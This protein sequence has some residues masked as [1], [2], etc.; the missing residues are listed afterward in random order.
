MAT[1]IAPNHAIPIIRHV[2]DRNRLIH[3]IENSTPAVIDLLV[4]DKLPIET[5]T[6]NILA[7][8]VRDDDVT[9]KAVVPLRLNGVVNRTCNV[10][11]AA[12]I[13]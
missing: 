11:T 13:L 4:V 10:R 9:D 8:R 7:S 2:T 1:T 12:D 6:A 5:I 3:L